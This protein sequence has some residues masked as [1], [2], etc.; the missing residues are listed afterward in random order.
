[1]ATTVRPLEARDIP[2][3]QRIYRLAFGTFFGVPD[4]SAF[5]PDL[6]RVQNR[7]LADPGAAFAAEVGGK[8]AGTNF[9]ANW[10][11]VGFFGPLTVHPDLWNLGIAQDLLEA[12]MD[13]FAAWGTS[14]AGLFTF[15]HSPK[16]VWLYQKFGFWPRFL[17][18][19]MSA[20]VPAGESATDLS[21]YSELAERERDTCLAA[22]RELTESVY[23]GLDVR[24]DI[25]A[26]ATQG[27]GDTVLIWQDER[28]AG[29]AIC[30]CGSGT[31]AG[32]GSCYVRF[33]AVPPGAAA[34][35]AFGRLLDA[36][37]ALAATRGMIRLEAGMNAGRS[38]AYAHMLT[39]GFRP[40]LIG[41]AMHRPNDPAYHRPEDWV[42]DDWR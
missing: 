20:P 1:M 19:I 15:G 14:Q 17:T 12:T 11:S 42:I 5:R 26:V 4:P 10:G 33:G 27:I 9:V 24:R 8:L 18:A 6:D 28:L 37:F 3:A 39:R 36:C 29:F 38:E 23:A 7:W 32:A 35:E 22:C 2:E 40:D 13:R 21:L 41:V 34:P 25:S 30:H 16:H 31:E